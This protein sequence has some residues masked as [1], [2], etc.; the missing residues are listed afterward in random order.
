MLPLQWLLNN[1]L[2]VIKLFTVGIS[3]LGTFP[4]F[5]IARRTLAS[6]RAGLIAAALYLVVPMAVLPP[7]SWG[8]T[9]NLF[10]EFFALLALAALV[11]AYGSLTP[12]RPAFWLLLGALLMALLSHPGVVQLTGVAFTLIILFWLLPGSTIAGRRTALWA[13]SG[14][15]AAT[16]VAY[17]GYYS[18]FAAQMIDTLR[19]MQAQRATASGGLHLKIG[20]SVADKS[21][22]LIVQTVNARS[23]WFFGGLRGFWQEAQAY[24]RVWPV[25]GSA[26]DSFS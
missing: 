26:L 14:L 13:L 1:E 2:L 11:G 10:G 24:Y 17:V 12:V 4:I 18:H 9:T 8:I 7:F 5:F 15:A 3:T 23:A 6:G 22:G 16:V 20:G 25:V 21:L 19:Q